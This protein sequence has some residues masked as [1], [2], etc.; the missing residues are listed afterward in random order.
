MTL[1]FASPSLGLAL[2]I[3]KHNDQRQP[4]AQWGLAFRGSR[5]DPARLALAVKLSLITLIITLIRFP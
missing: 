5:K 1:A 2:Y 4:D 3:V